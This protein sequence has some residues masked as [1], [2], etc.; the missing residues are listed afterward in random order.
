MAETPTYSH[1]EIQRYLQRTMSPQEMHDFERALMDDPFL[2]DA[3]EGFTSIDSALAT[4]HLSE[5]E[6]NLISKEQKAKVVPLRVKQTAWWRV[7]ALILVIVSAGVLTFGL[8]S[9]DGTFNKPSVASAPAAKE[10]I[11]KQDTVGP[12]ENP[13][14]SID[15]LP[16]REIFKKRPLSTPDAETAVTLEPP[17]VT[18]QQITSDT[19]SYSQNSATTT[20]DLVIVGYG[21]RRKTSNNEV[22]SGK[23]TGVEE[24]TNEKEFKGKVLDALGEPMP[25]VSVRA[26][27]KSVGTVS[28]SKGNF[29]LLSRDSVLNIDVSSPGYVT[30]DTKLSSDSTDNKVVL[31]EDKMSLAEVVVTGLAAK[32]RT[33][34]SKVK[35]TSTLTG[36]EPEGGWKNFE[37]YLTRQ[38][39]SLKAN[40]NHLTGEIVLD[41]SIDKNGHPINIK[42]QGEADKIAAEKA[43]MILSKG[44]KW[45][46]K[47]KEKKVSV[48]I[49]F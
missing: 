14:A 42:A 6:S 37:E 20:N 39:D 21:A 23:A 17:P 31:Q 46:K 16:K 29:T 22:L 12:I 38:A 19:L 11:Q 13:I 30:A 4:K 1:D 45:K 27:N 26:K 43:I 8:L 25:F 24:I 5:I 32:K 33:S 35:N 47:N 48:T 3:L 36:A 9:K 44:P 2:A 18:A 10:I 34:L 28:D 40:E 15:A 7:A 49:R 41:F